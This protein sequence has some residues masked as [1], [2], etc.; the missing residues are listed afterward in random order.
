MACCGRG[1]KPTTVVH[2]G[3]TPPQLQPTKAPEQRPPVQHVTPPEATKQPVQSAFTPQKRP[4]NQMPAAKSLPPSEE[5]PP[6]RYREFRS[7]QIIG[8]REVENFF[9]KAFLMAVRQ[10]HCRVC[11]KHDK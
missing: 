9:C 8:G 10:E 3:V 7:K 2:R 11:Q 6:C 1:R 4:E 5:L